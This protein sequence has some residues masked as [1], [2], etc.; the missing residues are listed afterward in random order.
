MLRLQQLTGL[1]GGVAIGSGIVDRILEGL[2]LCCLLMV[3]A[4]LL[5]IGM[6]TRQGLV[7]IAV[8][9]VV[10]ALGAGIFVLCGHRL[11]RW[12][13]RLAV[14][15]SWGRHIERWYEQS[16]AGLQV[17][18]SPMRLMFAVAMQGVVSLFDILA[19][20]LLI[21]AFGW[22]LPLTAGAMV[23]A[24]VAAA[25]ALP[26]SPGYVGV[27][28][29]AALFA[30]QSYGIDNSSSVAYGTVLQALTLILFVGV[31]SWAFL[32]EKHSRPPAADITE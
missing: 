27:Y 19:C 9:F 13:S 22:A 12:F 29:I 8:F 21:Q 18:R 31:G 28:Q 6:E 20:W 11:R 4:L 32:K 17:L 15:C 1:G 26:S 7:S 5:N 2:G 25:S 3:L 16:L 30:L 23:L 10:A 24:Y 14:A